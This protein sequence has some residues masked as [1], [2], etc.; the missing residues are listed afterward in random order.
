ML[1]VQTGGF[2][3]FALIYGAVLLVAGGTG[4]ARPGGGAAREEL[5]P[6]AGPVAGDGGLHFQPDTPA[7]NSR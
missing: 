5:L 1:Q 3:K 6:H 7:C 2:W 4:P